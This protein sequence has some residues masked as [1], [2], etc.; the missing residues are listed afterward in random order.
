MTLPLTIPLKCRRSSRLRIGKFFKG[1]F[2]DIDGTLINRRGDLDENI[3]AIMRAVQ[4]EGAPLTVIT[5]GK[6]DLQQEDLKAYHGIDVE[7]RSKYDF[8][9]ACL[10]TLIDD[11]PPLGQ[12]FWRSSIIR[13]ADRGVIYDRQD[14][15]PEQVRLP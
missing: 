1:T 3:V 13:R 15:R 14:R 4:A 5:G 9:G 11:V 2:I 10:E 6:V 8:R 7:V 12:R